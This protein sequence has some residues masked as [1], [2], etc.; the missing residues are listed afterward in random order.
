M[1]SVIRIIVFFLIVIVMIGLVS[2]LVIFLIKLVIMLYEWFF[3]DIF[4]GKIKGNW[5]L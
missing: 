2:C 1:G 5:V 4:L 3:V